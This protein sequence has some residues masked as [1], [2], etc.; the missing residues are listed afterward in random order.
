VALEAAAG[1][2]FDEIIIRL[3]RDL[4]GST[5][6]TMEAYLR[7]GI[8]SVSP[9]IPVR[10]INE[11]VRAIAYALENAQ[12]G[13]FI[14]IFAEDVSDSISLGENFKIIQDRRVLIE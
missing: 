6:E 1:A 11:E 8:D 3:D 14:S 9:D 7:E 2:M 10:T 5:P 12:P 4:R 13:S